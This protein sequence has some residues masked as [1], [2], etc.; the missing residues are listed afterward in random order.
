MWRPELGLESVEAI[1]R[2]RS[3]LEGHFG[4]QSSKR[5]CHC[6]IIPN[7][8]TV[9]VGKAEKTLQ[10]LTIHQHTPGGNGR[11]LHW[12]HLKISFSLNVS[13]EGN[14]GE[15]EFE[16]LGLDKQLVLLQVLEY[17]LYMVDVLLMVLRKDQD[18]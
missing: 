16:L 13:Q 3:P 15:M 2:C 6:A 7:E 17:G 10:L 5:S 14:C 18:V 9:D 12:I 1:L 8:L 4:D 11:N